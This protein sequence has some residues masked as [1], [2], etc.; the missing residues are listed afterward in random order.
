MK[1]DLGRLQGVQEGPWPLLDKRLPSPLGEGRG[2]R[3]PYQTNK[4][5]TSKNNLNGYGA[6]KKNPVLNESRFDIEKKPGRL[7]G[8]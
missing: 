1:N 7:R 8:V 2:D 6:S 5:M 3:K 4:N